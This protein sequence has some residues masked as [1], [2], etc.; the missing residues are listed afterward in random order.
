[1][2]GL[3]GRVRGRQR[4]V[5]VGGV[6]DARRD[7]AATR[8]RRVRRARRPRR[9]RIGVQN[10]TDGIRR[11]GNSR[12]HSRRRENAR[13]ITRTHPRILEGHARKH[14]NHGID[15]GD[16]RGIRPP[17]VDCNAPDAIARSFI[18]LAT[19]HPSE[20]MSANRADEARSMQTFFTHRSVS[21]FDRV[22]FQLTDELFFDRHRPHV[23]SEARLVNRRPA[24]AVRVRAHS[25]D[26]PSRA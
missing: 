5:S 23:M 7:I 21:I 14:R 3:A 11:I 19:Q 13:A 10:E 8:A 9:R 2:I 22:P 4:D 20:M 25:V 16:S 1:V 26:A 12:R 6:R 15:H 17:R 24:T 18:R